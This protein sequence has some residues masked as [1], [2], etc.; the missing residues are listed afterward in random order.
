MKTRISL[1]IFTLVFFVTLLTTAVFLLIRFSTNPE[2]GINSK[3]DLIQFG[4]NLLVGGGGCAA[5]WLNYRRQKSTE[6]DLL[7]KEKVAT[8]SRDDARDRHATDL[9]GKA[10][11]QFGSK[12]PLIK[13][14]G[15]YALERLGQEIPSQRQIVTAVIC[16]YLRTPTAP[17]ED[18]FEVHMAAQRILTA[19]LFPQDENFWPGLTVDLRGAVLSHFNFRNRSIYRGDFTDVEFL[20]D[21]KFEG[22]RFEKSVSFNG[23]K[24]RGDANFHRAHFY[25]ASFIGAKFEQKAWF[26]KSKFHR[27]AIFVGATFRARSWF[28][29]VRFLGRVNF[30]NSTF[31]RIAWVENSTFGHGANFS[32]VNFSTRAFFPSPTSMVAQFSI[33]PPWVRPQYSDSLASMTV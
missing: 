14:G 33:T 21:A 20:G 19:H 16:A 7:H 30:T 29:G 28:A 13:L 17:I 27:K 3:I 2:T 10:L 4:L 25:R 12:N 9:Y 23:A 11:E 18:D 26:T 6:L 1:R 32:G 15:L 22:V 31:D 8:D 24:F 5:L